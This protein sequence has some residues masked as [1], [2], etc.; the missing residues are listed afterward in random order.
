MI[1]LFAGAATVLALVG[2][3]GVLTWSVRQRSRELGIRVAL[4]AE[5]GQVLGLVVRQGLWF[6][7]I[8]L[9]GGL[10]VALALSRVLQT[11]L[12][13]VSPR[14]GLTFTVAGGTML[15]LTILAALGP[16]LSATRANPVEALRAD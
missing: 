11:L 10:L 7:G 9:T 2:A 1:L 16:A 8:G 3:Y 12:F 13:G 4:G 5:R 14:D 6:A 15:L